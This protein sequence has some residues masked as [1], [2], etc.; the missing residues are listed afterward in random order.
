MTTATTTGDLLWQA[1]IDDVPVAVAAAPGLVAVAGAEGTCTIHD[2]ATG[3]RIAS[4]TVDGGLL[5]A[6]FA[7]GGAHLAVTGT[8]G[9][10]LWH[11]DGTRLRHYGTGT[12]TSCARWAGHDRVAVAAGRRVVVHGSDGTELWRTGEAPSTITD[13]TW[14]RDGREVAASAY[15]GV[16]RYARHR[17]DPI[18]HFRYPGSHLAI[19]TTPDYRWIC[20]GN[21][22]RSVHIWRTR[23]GDELEMAGY[24]GKVTR[25]AFDPAGRW[26]ANNGASDITL[27]DFAGQGPGGSSPRLLRGHDTVTDLAWQPGSGS[28]LASAGSDATIAL[29]RPAGGIRSRTQ[30]PAQRI[31]LQAP[32]VAIQWLGTTRIVTA[33]STGTIAVLAS[34]IPTAGP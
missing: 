9:Y 14:L 26:L 3:Q 11:A 1:G 7:P 34:Q 10:A 5:H 28:I 32:A 27:W 2:A 33:T 31:Q 24:P 18:G 15:N 22:D 19:T 17:A 21:Q 6:A 29:W 12:W 13:L 25:L 23:D 16:Y 4:F 30:R 8:A 20:T